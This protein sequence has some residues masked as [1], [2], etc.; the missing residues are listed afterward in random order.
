M[1][2]RF[3]TIAAA[4]AVALALSCGTVPGDPSGPGNNNQGTCVTDFSCSFNDE[5]DGT[6]CAPIAPALRPYIQ[7]ASLLLREPL[8]ANEANWR[9]AH[10]DLLMGVSDVDGARAVNPNAKIFQYVLARFN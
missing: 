10:Y 1:S 7:T 2:S 4:I 8:D 5:C 9:A 3:F 6:A